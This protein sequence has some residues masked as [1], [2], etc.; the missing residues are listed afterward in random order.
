MENQLPQ[1]NIEVGGLGESIIPDITSLTLQ[2]VN[3]IFVG[4][5]GSKEWVLVDAGIWFSAERI[6]EAAAERFGADCPPQA[7]VL[8]HGHFDHIGALKTLL[9]RWDVPVYAHEL[10]MPY[11]TGQA[12]YPEPDPTVGG[13]LVAGMSFVFPNEPI[14]LEDR[15]QVLPHDG[16]VPAMPG[17]RWIHTPGHTPGHISLFRDEDRAMIAGDAFITVKQESLFAVLT[18]EKVLHGPPMYFTPDWQSAWE[19]VKKLAALKPSVA[20]TGHGMPMYGEDLTTGLDMLARDFDQ[21]AIPE[22]GRY[23]Q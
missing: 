9:E 14:N 4:T 7:I 20:Y 6:M 11:L 2:I 13:G 15:V 23:V 17:W 16:S 18:Q 8:T 5:P 3:V 12:S 21:I 19:S 10:E 1:E 22:H